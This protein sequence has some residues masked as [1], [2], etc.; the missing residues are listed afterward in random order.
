MNVIIDYDVGNIESVKRGFM[1]ANIPIIIS[2]D[3]TTIKQAE[4]LI[5]P[6]VGAF[7]NAMDSLEETGLIP[8]IKDHVKRGKLLIGICLGMQLLFDESVEFELTKGLG[9]IEGQ[10][11]YLTKPKKIPHM[12]WNDLTINH[13]D[14]ITTNFTTGEFAY[15]IHSLYA[16]TPDKYN[17]VY[18]TYGHKIPAIVRKDNVIGIQFHPEKSG[19]LGLRIIQSIK[20]MVR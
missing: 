9:F 6:G 5:L 13:K 17:L 1:R 16:K 11:V 4:L 3:E 18:T 15:F 2:K 8:L 10:I 20:E 19:E 14:P 7:K 12:G